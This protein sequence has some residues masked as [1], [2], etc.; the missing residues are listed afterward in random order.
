M[1]YRS[2]LA[3]IKANL[4]TNVR[5]ELWIS[6]LLLTPPNIDL[7]FGRVESRN[8]LSTWA[9]IQKLDEEAATREEEKLLAL[10]WIDSRNKVCTRSDADHPVRAAMRATLRT[11]DRT[12]RA[13]PS[14]GCSTVIDESTPS[15]VGDPSMLWLHGAATGR[16]VYRSASQLHHYHI[17][18][19]CDCLFFSTVLHH[20]SFPLCRILK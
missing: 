15:V 10:S 9:C 16:E 19:C 3:Y 8:L 12:K 13:D 11:G 7:S 1:Y 14:A 5:V 18:I 17:L 6:Q 4:L 2:S 20:L